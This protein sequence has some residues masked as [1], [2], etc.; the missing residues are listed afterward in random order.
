VTS[1]A[2]QWLAAADI[3]G[4]G[5]LDL[6]STNYGSN[7]GSILLGNGAAAFTQ[8]PSSPFA[9]GSNPIGL[10]VADLQPDGRLDM[11]IANQGS[12][13]VSILQ[14]N[15][16]NE[17]DAFFSASSTYSTMK[18]G[19]RYNVRITMKNTGAKPWTYANG[20]RLGSRNPRDNFTWGNFNR[21]L[22]PKTVS[23][24]PGASYD[25]DFTVT[26]PTTPGQYHF[27]WQMVEERIAWFGTV[28]FD[29]L[30]TVQ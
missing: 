19:Q 28:S 6:I 25:F 21:V 27:Q 18:A 30:V 22:L 7:T 12:N 29:E 14:N 2:P 23:V 4:D 17:L 16:P 15:C 13:T 1:A 8:S 3:N 9:T 26:A 10:A 11:V 20:D 24:P 5:F